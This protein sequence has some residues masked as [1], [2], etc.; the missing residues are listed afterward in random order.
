MFA[1]KT[2]VELY[3]H[4]T[5]NDAFFHYTLA[6][7][8]RRKQGDVMKLC[9]LFT[10][11]IFGVHSNVQNHLYF[12]II[13]MEDI[14]WF[15]SV[16]LA[17][18]FYLKYVF[19]TLQPLLRWAHFAMRHIFKCAFTW[20]VYRFPFPSPENITLYKLTFAFIIYEMCNFINIF[21]PL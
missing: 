2:W 13:T 5:Y 1:P 15:K 14:R 7:E 18:S 9:L 19:P 10:L 12:P 16:N 4:C 21:R 6:P 3:N 20:P 8:T 17:L 11:T